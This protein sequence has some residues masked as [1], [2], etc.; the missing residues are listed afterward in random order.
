MLQFPCHFLEFCPKSS[1]TEEET[2]FGDAIVCSFICRGE[3][4]AALSKAC[5][6][7]LF[8]W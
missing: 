1:G 5:T 6:L 4:F 2:L 3:T 7:L 8:V